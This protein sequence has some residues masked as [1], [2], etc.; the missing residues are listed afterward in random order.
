MGK[1]LSLFRISFNRT[2]F[3][4]CKVLHKKVVCKGL[5]TSRCGNEFSLARNGEL[6]I[7]YHFA[8]LKNCRFLVRNGKLVIGDYVGF[9][10]NCVVAC[11]EY[12]EIGDNV[13]FGPNVCIYDHDHDMKCNGGIKAGKF[14]TQPVK[15]GKNSWIGAN[16]IILRG[17]QIGENCIIAAGSV[18]TGI[19]PDNSTFI[20]KRER[21]IISN[22]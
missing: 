8:A 13:E 5:C 3:I 18:V 10:T 20:Q 1:L 7:G 14:L 6:H 16:V 9:N 21:T 11:H 19:V 2:R 15:I 17:A 4:F 22:Q 12:I